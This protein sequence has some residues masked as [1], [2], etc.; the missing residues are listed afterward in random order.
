[1]RDDMRKEAFIENLY[2]EHYADLKRYSYHFVRYDPKFTPLIEDCIQETF[3][4][5]T[6]NYHKLRKHENVMGWLVRT[7][8]NELLMCMRQYARRRKHFEGRVQM[9]VES[10][11]ANRDDLERWIRQHDAEDEIR[12]IYEALTPL[13]QG[14]FKDYYADNQSLAKTADKHGVTE[15]A[16]HCSAKRIRKKAEQI[17]KKD[18]LFIFLIQTISA[19]LRIV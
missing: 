5:A 8:G 17:A 2:R 1:M 7:C 13:E 19:F 15:N 4:K 14:I 6:A 3:A 12:R 9:D 10:A 16:V 18:F 11:A